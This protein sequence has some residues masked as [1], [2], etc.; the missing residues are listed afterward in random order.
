M[1]PKPPGLKLLVIQ[2][3]PDWGGAEEWMAL[4]LESI[5]RTYQIE[6]W[7]VTDLEALQKRWREAGVQT[8]GLPVTLDIIGNWKGLVKS[9]WRLPR[10]VWFY[11]RL[12]RRAKVSGIQVILMSGFSEK[13]LCS[14]I[15][16]FLGIAVVWYE[17]G[18]LET[19][20]KRNWGIPKLTYRLTKDIPRRIL[21]ISTNTRQA[22][23]QTAGLSVDQLRLIPPGV[24]APTQKPRARNKPG[25]VVGSL[26]R[27]TSEKGQRLLV[28]IWPQV[29]ESIPQAR[30]RL[31]GD[32]PDRTYLQKL[33]SELGI[34]NSVE[35]TGFVVD[36]ASFYNSLD[37]F[38]FAGLW[39]MEGFGLVLAEAMSYALPIVAFDKAPMAEVLGCAGMLVNPNNPDELAHALIELLGS[40]SKQVDLSH[41]ASQRYDECYR[42]DRQ[43]KRVYQQLQEVVNE[44]GLYAD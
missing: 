23:I 44:T 2:Q 37:I 18:P 15:A 21:T 27:L 17:Y 25:L 43:V 34:V 13:M 24:P 14:W 16:S 9:T 35:L 8:V 20:F 5:R 36:K 19:V 38:V 33:I 41:K 12:L 31:A 4:L 39:E 7:G 29:I 22:L 6:V 10:A 32:G 11:S 26:S 42:L 40:T 1:T 28:S 30:L 3:S